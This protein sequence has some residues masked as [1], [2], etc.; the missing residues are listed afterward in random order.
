[1]RAQ[2]F[3]QSDSP[4][5]CPLLRHLISYRM[6]AISGAGNLRTDDDGTWEAAGC[7]W[8]CMR[9]TGVAKGKRKMGHNMH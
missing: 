8:N 4:S 9:E 3:W 6:E 2:L 5:V 7:V 1:M